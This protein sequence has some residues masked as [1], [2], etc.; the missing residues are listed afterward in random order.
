M[1]ALKFVR[2]LVIVVSVIIMLGLLFTLAIRQPIATDAA[3]ITPPPRTLEAP[4]PPPPTSGPTS[5]PENGGPR[6]AIIGQVVDLSTGKPGA[7]IEIDIS[8]RIVRTDGEGRYSLTGLEAGTYI[9]TLSLPGDLTPAQS[10][11]GVFVPDQGTVNLDLNYYS[12]PSPT[13]T[14]TSTPSPIPQSPPTAPSVPEQTPIARRPIPT[15]PPLLPETGDEVMIWINPGHINNE[16]GVQGFI[17]INVANVVDF[18]AFQATLG[19]DPRIIEVETVTLGDFINSTGRATTP[20]VT[21][22][23][24]T[25]GE[26]SFVTFTSGDSPGPDGDGSLAVINF[27]SKQAGFSELELSGVRLF[28]RL[29]DY[30]ETSVYG[31]MV[32]VSACFGDLNNDQMIDIGDV[33]IVAGRLDQVLGDPN[34][35]LEFDLNNDGIIDSLDV[36]IVTDRLYEICP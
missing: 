30:I 21:E 22:V 1:S 24:N 5:K 14:P 4:P 32:N 26:I 16:Q 23:D 20:L 6:G 7:G 34:Y 29:G 28:S 18:G 10:S 33:Q 31:G 11:W 12:Q 27:I 13:P 9:V 2:G 3:A 36:T 19:F 8:G 25:T 15:P 35:V 17:S